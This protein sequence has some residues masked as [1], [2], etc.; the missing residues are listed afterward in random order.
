MLSAIARRNDFSKDFPLHR[1]KVSDGRLP[2]IITF[3]YIFKEF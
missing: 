2:L 1:D 3:R